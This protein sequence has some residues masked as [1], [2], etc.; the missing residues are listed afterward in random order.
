MLRFNLDKG[1]VWHFLVDKN[2]PWREFV[3]SPPQRDFTCTVSAVIHSTHFLSNGRLKYS[4]EHLL[5][6]SKTADTV[7]VS[8]E[9]QRRDIEHQTGLQQFV[10]TISPCF[11]SPLTDSDLQK[12]PS[13]RVLYMARYSEEK[14]HALLFGIFARVVAQEPD[15]EL[16]TWGSGPLKASLMQWVADHQLENN[17]HLHDFSDDLAGIHRQSCCAVLSSN[18]EGFCLFGLESLACGTPL[19]S[20]DINYGPR[21]LLENTGAGRLVPANDEQAMADALLEV[22]R[23]PVLQQEMQRHARLSAVR[24]TAGRVAERW[25]GWWREMQALGEK[26]AMCEDEMTS[27]SAISPPQLYSIAFHC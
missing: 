7:I 16:H 8:T 4:Y 6:A 12:T 9:E 13:K 22:L 5:Q 19:I 3:C 21:D 27:T 11:D 18:Q 10:R 1:T 20:F 23:N 14:Q 2:R 26:T 15:A 25:Q 17:I 24:F